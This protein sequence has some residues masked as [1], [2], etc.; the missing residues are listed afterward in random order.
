MDGLQHNVYR[1][2]YTKILNCLA[3]K[4]EVGRLTDVRSKTRWFYFFQ[5]EKLEHIRTPKGTTLR[6]D[7]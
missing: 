1:T 2:V 5:M 7:W 4:K 3:G 6:E